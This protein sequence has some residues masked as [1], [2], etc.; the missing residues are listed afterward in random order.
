MAS[1]T[2]CKNRLF[3]IYI[4]KCEIPCLGKWLKYNHFHNPLTNR[5]EDASNFINGA[6]PGIEGF[7]CLCGHIM[8][9]KKHIPKYHCKFVKQKRFRRRPERF[10]GVDFFLPVL[11]SQEHLCRCSH[12][13]TL[14][15]AYKSEGSWRI[16]SCRGSWWSQIEQKEPGSLQRRGH[17]LLQEPGE[18]VG[19]FNIAK[20]FRS[21]ATKKKTTI[22]ITTKFSIPVSVEV[23]TVAFGV[24]GRRPALTPQTV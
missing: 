19:T 3:G 14:R 12:M 24:R 6:M 13:D 7:A 21:V 16:W 5:V 1:K 11:A 9:E 23:N 4:V 20:S 18:N 22:W 17:R 8:L 15:V 2:W 10:M